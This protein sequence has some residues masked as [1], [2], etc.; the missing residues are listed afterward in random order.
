MAAEEAKK[1]KSRVKGN[2]R[3]LHSSETGQPSLHELLAEYMD[4]LSNLADGISRAPVWPS[5]EEPEEGEE[6]G[7]SLS[8]ITTAHLRSTHAI[9]KAED[10][11]VGLDLN[12]TT[13]RGEVEERGLID[14]TRQDEHGAKSGSL[15]R[16]PVQELVRVQHPKTG[17]WD[18]HAVVERVHQCGRAH[19]LRLDDGKAYYE[20]RALRI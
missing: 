6:S 20:N 1:L 19:L 18:Q 14:E 3:Q 2:L 17:R 11:S 4:V 15:C 13:R 10:Q 7:S 9:D 8:D 16:I 12:L 5:P